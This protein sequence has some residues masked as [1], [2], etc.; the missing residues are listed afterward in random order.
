M[1]DEKSRWSSHLEDVRRVPTELPLDGESFDY[2]SINCTKCPYQ[3]RCIYFSS[4]NP[5]C[6]MRKAILDKKF[7]KIEFTST[8]PIATNRLSLI[9]KYYVELSLKRL[10][11][12]SLDMVESQ[13]LKTILHELG[14]LAIDK[15][16]EL[17]D[18][19][20]KA[21]V[22]WLEDEEV[23]RLRE[24]VEHNQE[25]EQE[26]LVLREQTKKKEKKDE[27]KEESQ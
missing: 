20:S 19:K 10:F 17:I 2:A 22:P 11:G 15:K 18:Q 7:A 21:A 16:G 4:A 13:Y 23:K 25:L 12:I 24:M 8:D 6:G 1:P 14:Q 3:S 26:I 27:K 9:S 5:G